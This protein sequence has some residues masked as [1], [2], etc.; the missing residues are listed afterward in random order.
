MNQLI[1]IEFSHTGRYEFVG[2]EYIN[3][4]ITDKNT[5]LYFNMLNENKI[6]VNIPVYLNNINNEH[7]FII[8]QD[9]LNYT[10]IQNK[11]LYYICT[12]LKKKFES[13]IVKYICDYAFHQ[14]EIIISF[15]DINELYNKY[16]NKLYYYMNYDLINY[17]INQ[18]GKILRHN[19]KTFLNSKII[20]F[21]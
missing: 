21:N 7:Y 20:Y 2:F 17:K 1:R 16:N 4:D 13:H 18:I 14:S 12:E 3:K 6:D 8:Y 10:V 5:G 15:N 9:M 11:K 19:C